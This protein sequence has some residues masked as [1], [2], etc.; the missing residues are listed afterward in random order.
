MHRIFNVSLVT[1]HV[2]CTSIGMLSRSVLVFNFC[3]SSENSDNVVCAGVAV[4][5]VCVFFILSFFSFIPAMFMLLILDVTVMYMLR[6]YFFF[7]APVSR[8]K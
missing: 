2:L 1:Y 5:V 7:F 4:V 3:S 6:L 8:S